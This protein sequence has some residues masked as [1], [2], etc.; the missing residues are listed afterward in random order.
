MKIPR[1][2][3]DLL[4]VGDWVEVYAYASLE[5][6][7]IFNESFLV[8]SLTIFKWNKDTPRTNYPSWFHMHLIPI[9]YHPYDGG[10]PFWDGRK[11][12]TATVR[13]MVQYGKWVIHKASR[14][15]K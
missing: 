11:I 10:K 4:S 8:R 12:Q 1:S 6:K 3:K 7:L 2:N 5:G 13:E 9:F 14:N 15:K